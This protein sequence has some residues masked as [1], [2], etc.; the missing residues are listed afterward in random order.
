MMNKIDGRR[1]R[2]GCTMSKE[3]DMTRGE[4]DH[5]QDEQDRLQVE[6][7]RP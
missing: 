5:W 6:L 1:T 7:D 2:I 3:Q 4:Q